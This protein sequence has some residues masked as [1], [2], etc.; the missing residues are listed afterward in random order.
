[1]KVSALWCHMQIFHNFYLE[2]E[3]KTIQPIALHMLIASA[4]YLDKTVVSPE[5]GTYA[6]GEDILQQWLIEAAKC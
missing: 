4:A 3:S 2:P 6:K 5:I 1:M